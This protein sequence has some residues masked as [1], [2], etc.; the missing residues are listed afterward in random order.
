MPCFWIQGPTGETGP[1][2]ERGHPGPPG[3][4]GEQG[5]PGAGGKEGA[6]VYVHFSEMQG[7]VYSDLWKAFGSWPPSH[8]PGFVAAFCPYNFCIKQ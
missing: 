5:L 6:K 7:N 2:G 1:I 3:P 8:L 4:P